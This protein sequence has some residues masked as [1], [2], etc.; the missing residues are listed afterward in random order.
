MNEFYVVLSAVLPVLAIAVAGVAMRKL[1]WLT[2][3]ADHSLLR[4]TINLLVPAFIFDKV[5]NNPALHRTENLFLPPLVGFGTVALGIWVSWL[6]LRLAGLGRDSVGRTFAFSSG[7]YNYGYIPLPLAITLFNRETVG[8]LIVHNLGTEIAFW[9]L[10]T[11]VFAHAPNEPLWKK[12][13]SPPLL[14]IVFTLMLN[15]TGIAPHIPEFVKTTAH[16]LGACA[17]P[18]GLILIGAMVAD[19]LAEFHSE[20]GWRVMTASCVLRVGLIPMLFLVLA[21]F[22]PCSIELKRVIMLQAAMPSAVFAIIAARHFGGDGPTALRVVIA[23][24]AVGFVTIPLWIR[25][26]MKWLGL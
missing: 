17:I 26:G 7:L 11:I 18:M 22:L 12:L 15:L 6:A 13:L 25:V 16:M 14:A 8:V 4:V 9:L 2:E 21:K 20:Q 1:D 5:L 19:H 10:G 3:E 24:S 23:T